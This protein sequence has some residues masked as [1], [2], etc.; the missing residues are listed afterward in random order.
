MKRLTSAVSTVLISVLIGA[1]RGYQVLI[2]PL[3]GPRCRFRPTCSSYFIASLRKNGLIRGGW[4]GVCR[5]CRCH[6]W[7]RGGWDPP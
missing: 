4:K 2:S 6:P 7:S 1:V 5:I 3:L